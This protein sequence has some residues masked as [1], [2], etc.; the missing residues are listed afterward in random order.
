[1]AELS[2][3]LRKLAAQ[4]AGGPSFLVLGD[5]GLSCLGDAVKA[6]RWSGVYTS[7]LDRGVADAFVEVGRASSS[8]GAMVRAP[9]RSQTDLEVRYLFGGTHLPEG[10]QPPQTTLETARA[11]QRSNRELDRLVTETVTPRGA[12]L[13]EG[14]RP[15]QR[16][17]PADLAPALTLLGPGQAHLFSADTWMGDPFVTELAQTGQVTLHRDS[18]E[19]SLAALVKAGAVRDGSVAGPGSERVIALGDGFVDIDIHTWNQI[20]RSARPVDLE[21]LVPPIFSSQAARYQEFRSFLGATDAVP[22]WKAVGSGMNLRRDFEAHLMD[23]VQRELAGQALPSPILLSG[24]TASG[25][26]VALTA[27]A[28]QLA[29]TGEVAVLHQSRRTVRPS[30]EDLDMYAGWAAGHGAKA[31]VLIWDG[32]VSASEYEGVTRQLHARGRRVLVVGSKYKTPGDP[33]EAFDASTVIEAPAD[34]S[35][36]ELSRLIQTLAGVGYDITQPVRSLPTNFLGFLY[37]VLPETERQLRAGLSG[38]MRSAERL[39]AQLANAKGADERSPASL[40]AMQVA[41][42][43]AGLVLKELLP[44]DGSETPLDE[45]SFAERAPIQRVTTLVLVAGRHGI[46]VP[47]DLAL[48]LLGRE[49]YRSVRE[50]LA[51][52]DIVREID[53]DGG[54]FYLSARSHL[55]AEL[56]SQHE[57]PTNVEIEVL[58][59]VISNVRV[60]DGFAGGADE[61]EFL[62]KLLERVGPNSVQKGRYQRYFSEIASA[63]RSRRYESGRVHPRLALQE[64]NYARGDVYWQRESS[65]GSSEDRIASLEYNRDLLDEILAVEATR[66]LMRLSLS[67]ELASTLGAIVHEYAEEGGEV[68]PSGFLSR[69]DDVLQAVFAARAID[70]GNLHPVDVLAWSTRDAIKS[71]FLSPAQRVDRLANAIATIESLDR[72]SLT[73]KQRAALDRRGAELNQLLG[74]DDEAWEYLGSLERNTSPAAL[75]FLAQFEAQSGADGEAK[76]LS[77]LRAA[78]AVVRADWRCAQLLVDLTW[79][80][81]TGERLLNGE[82]VALHLDATGLSLIARLSTDLSD[83]EL[84]DSYRLDFVQAMAAFVGGRHA[85]ATKLFRTVTENTRQLSRRVYTSYVIADEARHPMV[86]TGRVESADTRYGWVWVNE[87]GARVRFE[88][89]IFSSTG[90]FARGQ[91]L[92]PFHIGFKLSSGA[93]AE[94]RNLYRSS[95]SR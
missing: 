9:S 91:K 42:R 4:L 39:M 5:D 43:D 14:W 19:A 35:T 20:R 53:D 32:M 94:P 77:R 21:L 72:S 93:V 33:P 45:Q 81:I 62:V 57:I 89:K 87:L 44:D 51:S 78:D 47:I 49:G 76:A 82:R 28:M 13:I 29:R 37:R 48:R 31:T 60:T 46:P 64:S 52:T 58:T 15:D 66:G 16:I 59:E 23:A 74:N 40:T 88:P 18:L 54:E 73:D 56:L 50:A 8:F 90:E 10:E 22:R 68:V 11:R 79:R 34:L 2:F 75:Y 71:G 38:E 24:Q 85:D 95:A 92:P 3:D 67:V 7:S 26:S 86:F 27:L 1:M 84:P 65:I 12:V 41:L 80:E 61:V 6:H 70:P 36:A 25:K 63:L 83:A 17:D 69:L 55:E 30:V